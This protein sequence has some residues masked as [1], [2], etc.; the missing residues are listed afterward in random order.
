MARVGHEQDLE[1]GG[2]SRMRKE[3]P[4]VGS[5]SGE[6]AFHKPC[7]VLASGV[8]GCVQTQDGDRPHL[9]M[10]P[11][12]TACLMPPPWQDRL[13]NPRVSPRVCPTTSWAWKD[14]G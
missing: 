12:N 1:R 2:S 7:L 3:G 14:Q 5:Q 9:L 13:V 6:M 10:G 11:G 4:N 8:A